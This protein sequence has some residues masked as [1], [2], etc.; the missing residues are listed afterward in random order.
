MQLGVADCRL[1]PIF[2]T[3]HRGGR[4]Q[5]PAGFQLHSERHLGLTSHQDAAG[6]SIKLSPG[7][8]TRAWLC[9]TMQGFELKDAHL[10]GLCEPSGGGKPP[11]YLSHCKA[12]CTCNR[13]KRNF[14]NSC[15]SLDGFTLSPN[16]CHSH[17][18]GLNNNMEMLRA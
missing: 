11:K 17:S 9:E 1:P 13:P 6:I 8:S 15:S 18:L 16:D 14:I 4:L 5:A 2:S 7:S 3:L 12:S 10:S